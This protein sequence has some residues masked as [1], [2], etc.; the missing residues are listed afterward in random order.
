[1]SDI[2]TNKHYTITV[3]VLQY[4]VTKTQRFKFKA[5]FKLC[6]KIVYFIL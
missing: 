1:M 4:I 2:H 5:Y 6:I 3:R